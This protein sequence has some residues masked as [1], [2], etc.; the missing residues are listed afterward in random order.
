MTLVGLM[1]TRNGGWCLGASVRALLAACDGVVVLDHAST[2]DTAQV[3]AG[4]P[5]VTVI[6]E[7][8]PTW[9]EGDF[10][11][12]TRFAARDSGATH[13]LLIDEDEVISADLA[14][15]LRAACTTLG[16]RDAVTVPWLTLVDD[17]HHYR[18]GGWGTDSYPVLFGADV[19]WEPGRPLLRDGRLP[20]GVQHL[21]SLEVGGL[22]HLHELPASRAGVKRAYYRTLEAL[23]PARSIAAIEQSYAAPTL[24]RPVLDLPP[25]AWPA[26]LEACVDL[27]RPDWRAAECQRL[28]QAHGAARFAGLDL[29][30]AGLPDLREVAP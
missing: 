7:P 21:H 6:H 3:L 26:G 16:P 29:R 5:G 9:H 27:E 18:R 4:I 22:L 1:T 23:A 20:T 25:G 12:R 10:H 19:R 2:D 15:A 8:H 30:G 24:S 28:W 13:Y 14:L 17:L 11:E